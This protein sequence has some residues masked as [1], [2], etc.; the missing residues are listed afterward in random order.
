MIPEKV[1]LLTNFVHFY[2]I[3]SIDPPKIEPKL[4]SVDG[5]M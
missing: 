3:V 1:K 5:V 4:F 2:L